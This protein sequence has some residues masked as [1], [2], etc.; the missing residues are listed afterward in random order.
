MTLA[1]LTA[2]LTTSTN[3]IHMKTNLCVLQ[4][5]HTQ[6]NGQDGNAGLPDGKG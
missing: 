2:L 4:A 1:L 5:V 6:T 3:V